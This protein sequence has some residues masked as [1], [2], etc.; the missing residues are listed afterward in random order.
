M[1]PCRS[2]CKRDYKMPFGMVTKTLGT[3]N[4]NGRSAFAR[5]RDS[6]PLGKRR[7]GRSPEEC[8]GRRQDKPNE[9]IMKIAEKS[10]RQR[11]GLDTLDQGSMELTPPPPTATG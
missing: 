9:T 5:F 3:H 8:L 7:E 4:P 2:S 10:D 6:N 11:W 1:K